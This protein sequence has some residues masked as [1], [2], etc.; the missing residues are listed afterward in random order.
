MHLGEGGH[1]KD[2]GGGGEVYMHSS[3]RGGMGGGGVVDIC[4]SRISGKALDE[5]ERGWER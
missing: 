4:A 3:I 5:K 2:G 1:K